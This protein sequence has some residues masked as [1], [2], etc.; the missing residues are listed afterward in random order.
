MVESEQSAADGVTG[1]PR[2]AYR[3][4]LS[5]GGML[6]TLE[7]AQQAP[8]N[9]SGPLDH[10]DSATENHNGDSRP[11]GVFEHLRELEAVRAE[12]A[13]LE[14]QYRALLGKLTTMRNTLGDKLRQDAVRGRQVKETH[15]L[16][17]STFCRM[18]WIVG[19]NRSQ[20]FKVRRRT[21]P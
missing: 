8:D 21:S 20:P 1:D 4:D 2:L 11:N 19:N 14:G 6:T 9:P 18:S 12:K 16:T 7:P 10:G 3:Q 15:T 5:A 13:A 17:A